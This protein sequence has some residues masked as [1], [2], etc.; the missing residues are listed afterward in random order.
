MAAASGLHLAPEANRDPL[1]A[2]TYGVGEL[3]KAL[4]E[5]GCRRLLVGLGG[6]ATNDGGLGLAQALGASF[7]DRDGNELGFGGGSLAQLAAIDRS[8]LDARIAET[9]IVIAS[10]VRSPLCGPTGAS[11]VFGPQK[12]ADAG[13]VKI[14]DANLEHL[15]LKVKAQFGLDLADT[16]GAGAA[17]GLGYGLMVFCGARMK[18]GIEIVLD[19]VGFDQYLQKC[20][21]VIT[22]EGKIDRQSVCG[23]VPVGVAER[24]KKYNLPVLAIVGD[25][26]EGAGAVYDLGVD[27][28][29]STVNKAMSLAEAMAEG[30]DLLEEAAERAMRIIKIGMALGRV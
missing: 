2:T 20:D 7:K 5:K 6:S 11:A 14:L 1:T 12:G 22:G 4:L 27:S 21:L 9:Q 13:A 30:G 15:A 10:D 3:I 24:A 17:G 25:I 8:G 26:G 16:P 29:M 23:K 28:I 18:A 19:C